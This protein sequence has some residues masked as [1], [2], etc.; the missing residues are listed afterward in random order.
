MKSQSKPCRCCKRPAEFAV[1]LIIS[2]LGVKPREQQCAQSISLCK[3]C[4]HDLCDS[5]AA[6]STLTLREA[7]KSALTAL[8][9]TLRHSSEDKQTSKS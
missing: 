4:I 1:L 6:K 8:T 3:R 9:Q 7:L 2:T 5:D